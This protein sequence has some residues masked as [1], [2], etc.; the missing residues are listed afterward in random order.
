[1]FFNP[2]LKLFNEYGCGSLPETNTITEMPKV[3]PTK[4]SAQE[5]EIDKEDYLF[6]VAGTIDQAIH[7]A[8]DNGMTDRSRIFSVDVP[9]RLY[10][11][12]GDG[13]NIYFYGEYYK[14]PEY[15]RIEETARCSGFALVYV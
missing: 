2:F 10:G 15:L 7:F 12:S 8:R 3:K 13:R 9:E 4:D 1:M 6:V 5:T 14:R 11:I